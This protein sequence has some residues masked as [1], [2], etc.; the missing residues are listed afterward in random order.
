MSTPQLT[1]FVELDSP[2][3]CELFDNPAVAEFLIKGRY[4]ISMGIL[5]LTP[6]RAAVVRGLEKAEV[7]VTGW[8]LL[9]VADGYWFNADNVDC[10]VARYRETIEWAERE[11]LTLHRIGLDIEFPRGVMEDFNRNRGKAL[12]RGFRR[13]RS[14]QQVHASELAYARL[15][16]EIHQGLRDVES[17][18]FPH[19]L[20]E[21]KAGRSLLRRTLGLVDVPADVEVFMLYASYLGRADAHG[22]FPEAPAIALGVTGGGVNAG[23]PEE[24]RRLLTWERLEEDLVTAARYSDQLYV[25]SL[26]GCVWRDFLPRFAAIDWQASASI[27]GTEA[28]VRARRRRRWLRWALR[29]EPLADLVLPSTRHEA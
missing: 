1:F 16:D 15:V 8:L 24:V 26:E 3:L 23:A 13:R 22:Y 14:A 2:H 29:A 10:A 27:D 21:R 6:E 19:L 28:D 18:H 25:F 7:P 9:D 11:G 12:W 4:A 20:D 5:D 17:Y